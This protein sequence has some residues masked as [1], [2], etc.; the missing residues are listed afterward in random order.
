MRGTEA[1]RAMMWRRVSWK[2]EGAPDRETNDGSLTEGEGKG[3]SAF[4]PQ[5]ARLYP[6][7]CC[8][9]LA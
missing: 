9:M 8:T 7:I 4:I 2:L 3:R 6:H 1:S 5:T